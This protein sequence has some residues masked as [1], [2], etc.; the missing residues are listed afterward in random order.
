MGDPSGTPV[1]VYLFIY[2]DPSVETTAQRQKIRFL[3]A[4]EAVPAGVG[5][6]GFTMKGGSQEVAEVIR[7]ADPAYDWV[8]KEL[9]THED[10]IRGFT[11]PDRLKSLLNCLFYPNSLEEGE[12][13]REVTILEPE[14]PGSGPVWG[15]VCYL[16]CRCKCW[17]QESEGS[18]VTEF[19][20]EIRRERGG[21]VRNRLQEYG[22]AIRAANLR[23][24]IKAIALFCAAKNREMEWSDDSFRSGK[25]VVSIERGM[26]DL[27]CLDLEFQAIQVRR[28]APV[29]FGG[30]ELGPGGVEWVKLLSIRHWAKKLN[31]DDLKFP[32]PR[33]SAWKDAINSAF[34]F[35]S[36]MSH[37]DLVRAATAEFEME[38]LLSSNEKRA[39]KETLIE[40]GKRMRALNFADEQ[41]AGAFGLSSEEFEQH[42]RPHIAS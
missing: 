6:A 31:V 40:L 25:E 38:E 2:R 21:G 42:Y 28:G 18:S 9:F 33:G 24:P 11:G 3:D 30:K 22:A 10:R 19:D 27:F 39:R 35:L 13:I 32:V 41:I 4:F 5:K 17:T 29:F 20:V 1:N 26:L 37:G 23:V 36:L 7:I 16:R 15:L 8:F 12:R 14:L 34:K